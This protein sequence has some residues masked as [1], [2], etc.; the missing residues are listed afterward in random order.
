ML[1]SGPA[2]QDE[3]RY[4]FIFFWM[5]SSRVMSPQGRVFPKQQ[6]L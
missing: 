5:L 2:F 1:D 6:K 4:G 3:A